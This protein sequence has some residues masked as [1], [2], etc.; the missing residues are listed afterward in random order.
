MKSIYILSALLF[1]LSGNGFSQDSTYYK[2][3]QKVNINKTIG[4]STFGQHTLHF[5]NTPPPIYRDTRL[6]SSSPLYN[7]YKK[8]DY[9][10]GAITTNPNKTGTPIFTADDHALKQDSLKQLYDT[11]PIKH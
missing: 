6:G 8:N 2:T 9:G 3:L 4:D 7:T 11:I 1:L 10:A 5:R